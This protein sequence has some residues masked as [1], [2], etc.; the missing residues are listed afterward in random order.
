M[1]KNL[2]FKEDVTAEKEGKQYTF[3]I[4]MRSMM[5]L[6]PDCKIGDFSNNFWFRTRKAMKKGW[7]GYKDESTLK[8]AVKL[9][10]LKYGFYNIHWIK[11]DLS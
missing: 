9:S 7:T 4:Q 5:N 11:N 2:F 8:K 10:L 3:N 1:Y 6:S